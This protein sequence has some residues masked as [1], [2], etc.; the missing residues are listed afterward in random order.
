M[1]LKE[2]FVESSYIDA[3]NQNLYR[4]DFTRNAATIESSLQRLIQYTGLE[5]YKPDEVVDY[6]LR[7]RGIYDATLFACLLT[8][9]TFPRDR[10]IS[11]ELYHDPEVS[12]EY[13][14]IYIRQNKY[15]P[16]I[17]EKIDA[18]CREYEPALEGQNGWI[19]VTTDFSPP[20]E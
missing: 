14:S 6:L 1:I 4:V 17:I 9:E 7:Y 13:I 8:A 12:D 18:I 11:I 5:I 15:D 3:I 2:A 19:L 20:R 16:D 10:Q